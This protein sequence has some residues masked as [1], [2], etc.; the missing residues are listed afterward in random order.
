MASPTRTRG[1]EVEEEVE[2]VKEDDDD[3]DEEDDDEEAS[4]S[5]PSMTHETFVDARQR[6]RQRRRGRRRQL[7]A[8][9]GGERGGQAAVVLEADDEV[10]L[11]EARGELRAVALREAARDDDLGRARRRSSGGGGD[12][13]SSGG[14][15]GRLA[16]PFPPPSAPLLPV[17]LPPAFLLRGGFSGVAKRRGGHDR[18]ERLGLGVLDERAGVYDDGVGLARVLDELEARAGEVA[19]EDLAWGLMVVCYWGAA[20]R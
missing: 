8:E 2:E 9:R 7:R 16:K 19:E 6:E 20:V 17:L 3:D 11:R 4:F 14:G 12:G 1:E 18:V 5:S 10:G 13:S 15:S